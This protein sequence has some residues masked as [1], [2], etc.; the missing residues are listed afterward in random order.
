MAMT[1]GSSPIRLEGAA[2]AYGTIYHHEGESKDY[3][4]SYDSGSPGHPLQLM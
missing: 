2:I 1:V 4:F 3:I